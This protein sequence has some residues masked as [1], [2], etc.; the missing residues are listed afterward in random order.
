MNY[1]NDYVYLEGVYYTI[2]AKNF[3]PREDEQ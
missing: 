3:Y 2:P 1:D